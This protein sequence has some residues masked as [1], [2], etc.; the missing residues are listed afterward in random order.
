MPCKELQGLSFQ[1]GEGELH[2]RSTNIGK[3]ETNKNMHI[4]KTNEFFKVYYRY[5]YLN[6]KYKI[7]DNK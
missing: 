4:R 7:I 3:K 6:G 5:Y 1:Q 2:L